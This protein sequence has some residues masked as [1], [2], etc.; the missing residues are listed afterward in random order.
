MYCERRCVECA[1]SVVISCGP[2][3]MMAFAGDIEAPAA[4]TASGSAMFTL[5]DIYNR[6]HAGM[7]GAKRPGAFTGP[8]SGPGS[9]GKT[10]ND[11]MAEA[12]SVDAASGADVADVLASKKFWG[13]KSGAG[14]GLLT[15][16]MPTQ[17]LSAADDTVAAGYYAATT[18]SAEDS[19]L[20]SANIMS[21]KNIFGFA[22]DSN[23][24]NTSSGDAA[25]GDILIGKKAWVDGGEVTGTATDGI[26]FNGV[27]GSK[28]FKIPDGLY[29]GSKT[30]TAN[31]TNLVAANIKCGM[32]IFGVTGS[33]PQYVAKTGQTTCYEV[34]GDPLAS[35]DNTG[36]DAEYRN[37]GLPVVTPG[38]SYN[39][40]S[41]T[42]SDG[43]TDNGDGTVT[44]NLTGL[45]W[46]ENANCFESR[47]WA[48]ALTDCNTL[49]DGTCGLND[50]SSAGDWRLP[51]INELRSLS[52]TYPLSS[53]FENV[54]SYRYWSST[55]AE[56]VPANA[57][58]VDLDGDTFS[59]YLKD[60]GNY[61]VWPV[62]GG[63]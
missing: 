31:D 50:G 7:E 62:R 32:T 47:H 20:A 53:Y 38:V 5:L 19:D 41:F 54:Q 11:M 56:G 26:D 27:D 42:C 9:T 29:S 21:G 28:S 58:W 18:L 23:V 17:T 1:F 3:V 14:W 61:Y 52:G 8:A 37:G 2:V 15:G 35:C 57:W 40:T 43:F 6:L 51:N 45:I 13:L 10:L 16:T 25:E 60:P 24:V 36:Q 55:T 34:D 63:Q 12:P 4:P 48:T 44:D 33:I 46:L 59:Y 22:S 49:A 39:R 30:A